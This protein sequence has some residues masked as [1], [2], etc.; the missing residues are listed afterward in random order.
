M[1]FKKFWKKTLNFCKKPL[2]LL[3]FCKKIVDKD[4]IKTLSSIVPQLVGYGMTSNFI[5]FVW[6]GI[7]FTWYSWLSYGLAYL[8]IENKIIINLR[9]LWFK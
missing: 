7:P 5:L 4:D 2:K 3:K 1:D 8:I 6:F 9:R